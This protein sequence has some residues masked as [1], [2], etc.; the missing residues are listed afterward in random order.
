[1]RTII[2]V[3]A[4]APIKLRMYIHDA[5]HRRAHKEI[6]RRYRLELWA[7]WK[8]TGRSDT[9]RDAVDLYVTFINPTG[10]DIDNLLVSTFQALDGKTGRGPTILADDRLVSFVQARILR[11]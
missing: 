4:S 3:E 9:I 10:P 7:A 1:M 5:P 11:S 2:E 6:L 8:A